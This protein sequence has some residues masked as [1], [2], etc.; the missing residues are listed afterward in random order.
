MKITCTQKGTLCV[1]SCYL[2]S[3]A[4]FSLSLFFSLLFPSPHLPFH[5]TLLFFVSPSELDCVIQDRD[6]YKYKVKELQR[7]KERLTEKLQ[8]LGPSYDMSRSTAGSIAELKTENAKLK[9]ED[10]LSCIMHVY[11]SSSRRSWRGHRTIKRYSN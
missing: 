4:T 7:E 1:V 10:C 8:S 5:P 11:S 3:L 6:D 9:V 2:F